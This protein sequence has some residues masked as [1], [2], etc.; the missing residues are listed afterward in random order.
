MVQP[1]EVQPEADLELST[2]LARSL[3]RLTVLAEASRVFA[4]YADS[5]ELLERIASTTAAQIGDGCLIKLLD[6]AGRLQNAASAHRDPGLGADWKAF[7]HQRK[8]ANS[9]DSAEAAEVVRSGLPHVKAEIEPATLAA[10]VGEDLR[11]MFERLNVCGFAIVPIRARQAILGTLALVRS[12]TGAPYTADDVVLLQELADRAGLAIANARLYEE[13]QRQAAEL[14]RHAAIIGCSSDAIISI[15]LDGL[16]VTWNP[17]AERLFGYSEAEMLGRHISLLAPP[18]LRGETLAIIA[19]ARDGHHVK[20]LETV[21]RH[22]S[23]AAVEIS[24]SIAPILDASGAMCGGSA[25]LRDITERHQLERQVALSERMA[26]VGMLAAGVAHEINNPLSYVLGNLELALE[27]VPAEGASANDAMRAFAP[28]LSEARDGAIRIARIVRGLR[29]FTRSDEEQRELLAL[30]AI[31]DA[32][33]S[34]AHN[35]LRH[36]AD[37]RKQYGDAPLVSGD[38]GRLVQVFVNLL[39]NAA[40][41]L[42]ET[43]IAPNE[44]SIV[45]ATAPDGRAVVQVQDNGA[46]ISEADQLRI[47]DA[48]Y[49]TKPIGRGTGLGLSIC[50][51][52]VAAHQGEISVESVLG[53]GSTFRVVLP[54]AASHQKPTGCSAPASSAAVSSARRGK[55]LVVDDEPLV[56]KM[57]GQ[58]LAKEHDVTVCHAASQA[59]AHLEKG[60]RFD[61]ILC[62]LMMPEMTGVELYAEFTKRAPEQASR[63]VFTTGGAFTASSRA[64]LDAIP[65]RRIDKPCDAPTLQALVRDLVKQGQDARET[66]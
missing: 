44:I 55:V 42:P 49:T 29:A 1:R 6:G 34:L 2:E 16:V 28:L 38:E 30:P 61:V 18:E 33:L 64:F 56:A 14:R 20:N 36:R 21:R 7:L 41:A 27:H 25:I 57:L 46:G 23:G 35:E 65:N 63:M 4:E 43:P 59:L 19:R 48:F 22:K 37:V 10:R 39:V 9:A 51:G 45:I 60:G 66:T 58:L 52:I 13:A 26:S 8:A 32:A 53:K 54:A 3:A 24:M 12:R 5:P 47:F 17:A 62:D 50:H 11:P 31:L 15:A 40:H